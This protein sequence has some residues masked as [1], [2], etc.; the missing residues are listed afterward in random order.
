MTTQWFFR[1]TVGD[2]PHDPPP[3]TF[4]TNLELAD[5]AAGSVVT[6]TTATAAGAGTPGVHV[7]A[8][9]GVL[10][11]WFT[12]PLEAVTI[13][14][15]IS[16]ALRFWESANQA[17]TSPYV[18]IERCD[19][20]GRVLSVIAQQAHGTEA[21]T[22]AQGQMTISITAGNVTDTTLDTGDRIKITVYGT[23]GGGTMASGRTFS[24]SVNGASSGNGDSNVTFTESLTINTYSSFRDDFNRSAL[25]TG[26]PQEDIGN[27]WYMVEEAFEM[28]DDHL[29]VGTPF[30][31]PSTI[32]IHSGGYLPTPIVYAEA[33]MWIVGTPRSAWLHARA[34]P[35]SV[36]GTAPSVRL[37]RQFGTCE[38]S[39]WFGG[40]ERET[41]T[42]TPDAVDEASSVVLG[43]SVEDVGATIE[44][45]G[46]VDRVAFGSYTATP[47]QARGFLAVGAGV[48]GYGEVDWVEVF[49][50]IQT[51]AVTGWLVGAVAIP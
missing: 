23:D 48:D 46:Y 32:A 9:S 13:A 14:G 22:T 30:S 6:F 47:A 26:D 28:R 35:S 37:V 29:G 16:V 39:L 44:I 25:G 49:D 24:L 4:G 31:T 20:T 12:P 21:G 45:T 11:R 8:G 34:I 17:N 50:A 1:S 40:V 5:S 27:H 18:V 43:I 38:A 19:G 41:V 36:N 7:D 2:C 33:R 15:A 3:S 42:V 51:P 10:A